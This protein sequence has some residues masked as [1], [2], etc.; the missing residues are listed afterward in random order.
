MTVIT[1]ESVKDEFNTTLDSDILEAMIDSSIDTVNSDAG[2]AIT[3]MTGAS[4]NKTVT[5]TGDQAAAIKPL[6]AMK[7]ISRQTMGATSQSASLGGLSYSTS[8]SASSGGSS[9]V[10][11][12][13]YKNAIDKLRGVGWHAGMDFKRT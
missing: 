10:N 3:Y 11:F 7:I 13:L 2:L 6:L 1:A 4:P 9:D 12:T 8:A 5:V